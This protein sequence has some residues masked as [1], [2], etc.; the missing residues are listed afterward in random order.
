MKNSISAL[1]MCVC[2]PGLMMARSASAVDGA[3]NLQITGTIL[4]RSC[5][6]SSSSQNQ[7]VNI[8][9]FSAGMFRAAGDTSAAKPFSIVLNNC[10]PA[11]TGVKMTFSGTSDSSNAA[12]LALSDT[13]G[14]GGM[15][16]GV[17]V[18]VLDA[19]Q[20][21]LALNTLSSTAYAIKPGD[22]TLPFYLRYKS[23][24]STITAGNASAVMYFDLQYQ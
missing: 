1:M 9:Q 12:L 16:S 19:S 24:Q 14:N 3:Y 13:S 17:G 18:E 4:S 11:A 22:N 8:G 15:A 5:E 23:T 2:A 6:V 21:P 10:G 20:Q 7:T